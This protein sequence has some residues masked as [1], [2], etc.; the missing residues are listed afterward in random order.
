MNPESAGA[1]IRRHLEG[2]IAA[3][4]AFDADA[5]IEIAGRLTE[6]FRSGGKLLIAGNG[7]SAADALHLASEFVNRLTADFERDGLP[8][9]ALTTDVSVLTSI[10]NDYGYERVFARQIEAL[11]R[12]GDAIMLI[13]TS[14]NAANVIAAAETAKRLGMMLISTLR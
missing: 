10:A 6:V 5:T 13:S 3:F 8:A 11:G 9:I 4:Q 14:G 2:S 12:P 1:L 7:G